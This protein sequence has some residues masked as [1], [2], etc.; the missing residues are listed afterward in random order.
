MTLGRIPH[1]EQHADGISTE[2]ARD[3]GEHPGRFLVEPLGVVNHAQQRLR[4]GRAGQQGQRGVPGR[5]EKLVPLAD[6]DFPVSTDAEVTGR[7]VGPQRQVELFSRRRCRQPRTTDPTAC[8][9]LR[10][11]S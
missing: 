9:G 11:G 1:G 5:D 2:A 3:E 4:R 6:R 10:P 7:A 8:G